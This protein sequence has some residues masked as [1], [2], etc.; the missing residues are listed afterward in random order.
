VKT[1][2]RFILANQLTSEQTYLKE[3][4]SG[5][6]KNVEHVKHII[7][8]QQSL[9]RFSTDL[10]NVKIHDVMEDALEMTYASVGRHQIEITREYDPL[11]ALWID[12]HKVIQILMNL[13]TNAKQ[14]I[15]KQTGGGQLIL[16]IKKISENRAIIQVADNGM[17]IAPE[18]LVEIFQYGFTT[19]QTGN[20]FGLHNSANT[21]TEIGGS[22]SA[23]SQGIGHGATFTLEIPISPEQREAA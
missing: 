21:A 3:E 1:G 6:Q 13:L 22:L 16:R 10:E 2:C 4:L 18:N 23:T 17:G 15:N 20:G 8:T 5:L 14:A 19:K 12:R 11:P 7:A 9:A